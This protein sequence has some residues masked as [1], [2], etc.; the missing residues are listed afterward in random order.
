MSAIPARTAPFVPEIAPA[1]AGRSVL[2][3]LAGRE[4]SVGTSS[5]RREVRTA[6]IVLKIAP[7]AAICIA[8]RGSRAVSPFQIA[9]ITP[10][11][12]DMSA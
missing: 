5:A 1:R 2:E 6:P 7:V 8:I 10:V 3:G 9:R 11:P 4:K 12:A